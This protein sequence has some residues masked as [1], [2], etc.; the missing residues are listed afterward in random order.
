LTLH[1]IAGEPRIRD[2]ELG[3]KLGYSRPSKIRE[4]IKSY[5]KILNGISRL[6]TV[7][8]RPEGGGREVHEFFLNQKQAIFICM[9]SE[10]ATAVDVQIDITRVYDAH[11]RGGR[12]ELPDFTN[13]PEAARAWADQ[14]DGRVNAESKVRALEQRL[15]TAEADSA[16]I[17]AMKGA[18][19]T[20][21]EWVA[22]LKDETGKNICEREL[23]QWLEDNKYIYRDKNGHARAYAH[24]ANLFMLE[25]YNKNGTYE[26]V[27]RVTGEGVQKLS[28]YILADANEKR[29]IV[30][31]EPSWE[32]FI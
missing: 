12:P 17:R 7:G 14:F 21:R 22:L 24:H 13:P 32:D 15:E 2:V 27:L 31:R 8:N 28:P 25:P 20:R 18:T 5:S 16:L 1:N 10:T 29:G 9:K 26:S 6:P 19:M 4:I 3:Q 30:L 11:L 23:S